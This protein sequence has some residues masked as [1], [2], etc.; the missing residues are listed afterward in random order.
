MVKKSREARVAWIDS[1]EKNITPDEAEILTEALAIMVNKL[2]EL[3][4]E[5]HPQKQQDKSKQ[6]KKH[7]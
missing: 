6:E 7:C 3:G 5:H 2:K 4:P 1:L